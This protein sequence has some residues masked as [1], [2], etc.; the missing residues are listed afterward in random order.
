MPL[1]T[2]KSLAEKREQKM[3]TACEAEVGSLSPVQILSNHARDS[4]GEVT[5]L[6]L[7]GS[8][9]TSSGPDD[10]ATI[11]HLSSSFIK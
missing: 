10:A 11:Y 4:F 1:T 3:I 8:L 5:V 2:Q 7:R 9:L 6:V